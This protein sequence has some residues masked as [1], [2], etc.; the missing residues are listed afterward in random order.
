I[1]DTENFHALQ[2]ANGS[3]SAGE[4]G[5][6]ALDPNGTPGEDTLTWALPLWLWDDQDG[7]GT[8]EQPSALAT[9]GV[10]RGNDR[11]FYWQER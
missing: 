8:L 1:T 4:G 3:F 2:A 5:P 6:L 10:Y 11:V 9:F 7:D